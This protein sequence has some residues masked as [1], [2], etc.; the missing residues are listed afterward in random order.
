MNKSYLRIPVL[1]FNQNG[2]A[3]YIGVMCSSDIISITR[4]DVRDELINPEGYQRFRE[5]SRCRKIAEFINQPTSYL[6]GSILINLRG[7]S[8]FIQ[9]ENQANFGVLQIPSE[10]GSAWLI[11][12]Q[13]RMGGFEYTSR[14]LELPVVFFQNLSHR[15]EMINFSVIND[16]QKGVNTSLT[17]SLLSELREGIEDWKIRAHDIVYKLNNDPTSPWYE[18]INMTGAKGMHRPVNLAS[19]SNSL[20]Y[21]IKQH[22]LFQSLDLETQLFILNRFWS[23]T[24]EIFPDSWIDQNKYLLLKSLGVYSMSRVAAYVFDLCTTNKGDFS[25]DAF[26]GYMMPLVGF[27]WN[28]NSSP[29][30]AL[31]GLKGCIEASNILISK[32]HKINIKLTE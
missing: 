9:N 24:R 1:H 28:R 21:L 12:G 32:L 29:F 7:S 20:K 11:D 3:M 6:P 22:S 10:K 26:R 25:I 19:F 15:L 8:I 2:Q 5:D 13:H 14:T 17:L 27:D 18:R 23:V 4:V 30:K 16:T 31:G